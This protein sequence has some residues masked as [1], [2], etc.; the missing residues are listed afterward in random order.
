MRWVID[1]SSIME[2]ALDR[3]DI[4]LSDEILQDVSNKVRDGVIEYFKEEIDNLFA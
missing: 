2:S 1:I 3:W 4:T